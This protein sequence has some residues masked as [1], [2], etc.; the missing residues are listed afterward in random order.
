MTSAPTSK[1]GY[2]S[3]LPGITHHPAPAPCIVPVGLATHSEGQAAGLPGCLLPCN[4]G[5]G[6]RSNCS[7]VRRADAFDAGEPCATFRLILPRAAG[8]RTRSLRPHA[9]H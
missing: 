7:D 2:S 8:L 1:A 9:S 4:P 6:R 5:L 3:L